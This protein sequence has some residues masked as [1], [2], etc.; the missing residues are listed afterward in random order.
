M[1][2]RHALNIRVVFERPLTL[3]FLVEPIRSFE[4]A[5]LTVPRACAGGL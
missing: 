4:I 2:V 1:A 5:N 3:A